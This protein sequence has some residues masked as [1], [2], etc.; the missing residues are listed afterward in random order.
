MLKTIRMIAIHIAMVSIVLSISS[1][2]NYYLMNNSMGKD[3]YTATLVSSIYL[4]IVL[5]VNLFYML[6][7]TDISLAEIVDLNAA[8]MYL[9]FFIL[10]TLITLA[11]TFNPNLLVILVC[12]A[13][14]GLLSHRICK[15]HKENS[16]ISP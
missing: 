6:S 9:I 12:I 11:I 13:G 8:N 15:E 7:N 5:A 3:I 10:I 1:F 16:A 2:V 4:Q 14:N